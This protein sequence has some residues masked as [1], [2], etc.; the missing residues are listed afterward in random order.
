M[1]V[2]ILTLHILVASIMSLAIIGVFAAGYA[3]RATKA[4]STMLV[5]FGATVVSGVG[6]LFV[7][8]NGLGRFCAM[9]SAFTVMALIARAYYRKRV[10]TVASL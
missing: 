6:L 2:F 9:M 3:E 10:V 5:S 7:S 8:P 1:H 4:Y